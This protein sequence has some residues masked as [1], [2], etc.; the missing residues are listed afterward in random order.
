M[1]ELRRRLV[2]APEP[3]APRECKMT[4]EEGRRRAPAMSRLFA[5][6]AAEKNRDDGIEYVFSGDPPTLWD[7][8]TTYVDEEA[9]CCPFF[10]FDQQETAEGVVLRVIAPPDAH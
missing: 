5:H 2:E 10:A 3:A 6:L 9:V 7:D 1:T 8:V 4:P